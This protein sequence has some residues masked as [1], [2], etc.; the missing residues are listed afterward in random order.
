LKLLTIDPDPGTKLGPSIAHDFELS[1]DGQQ[2]GRRRMF[3]LYCELF[4]FFILPF[5]C[6]RSVVLEAW[7]LSLISFRN[8]SQLAR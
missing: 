5:N 6:G 8:F 7:S 2:L 3:N 4:H 1:C